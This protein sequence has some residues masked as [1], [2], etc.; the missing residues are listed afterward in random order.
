MNL[1]EL[2]K[3]RR[4][5]RDFLNKEV[6]EEKLN[7][8]LKAGRLAPSGADQK[9]YVYIA[10]D[11]MTLKKEIKQY[12]EDADKRYY[13]TSEEWFKK[14]ME[15]KNISLEKNFLVDAP[16][17]IVVAGETDKPHWLEST[18]MSISYMILAAEN[19]GLGTLTYTPTDTDFIKDLLE[20][21]KKFVPVTII[22][23]GYAKCP[24]EK[25]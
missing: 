4:S 1:Y 6:P 19:E 18:W 24:Q 9:P 11:D 22:P 20:L 10:V 25:Y 7:L 3:N 8:I 13:D 2:M 12:C 16:Y 14:W 15:K 5:T 23:I 21:P 17:L